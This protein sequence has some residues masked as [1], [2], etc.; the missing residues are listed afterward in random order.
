MALETWD[1]ADRAI[2]VGTLGRTRHLR[3]VRVVRTSWTSGILQ[4]TI[5]LIVIRVMGINVLTV[6][7][8]ALM[9]NARDVP[10]GSIELGSM[11][12]AGL[13]CG[14]KK[15][16]GPYQAVRKSMG[17]MKSCVPSA[18]GPVPSSSCIKRFPVGVIS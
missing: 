8:S 18:S 13:S 12:S 9:G 2:L 4:D 10:Q 15:G 3:W 16:V 17:T 11:P 5:V 1:E 14:G 7:V 6:A